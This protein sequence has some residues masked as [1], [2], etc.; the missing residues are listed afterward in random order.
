MQHL[1]TSEELQALKMKPLLASRR[2]CAKLAETM[3]EKDGVYTIDPSKASKALTE[4]Q[5][6]CETL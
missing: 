1:L 6:E 2:L 5:Q 3:K 4:F